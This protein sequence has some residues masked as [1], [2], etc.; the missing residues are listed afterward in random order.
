MKMYV[1]RDYFFTIYMPKIYIFKI[2]IHTQ[3]NTEVKEQGMHM[4]GSHVS[5][6][7]NRL[8]WHKHDLK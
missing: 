4:P 5:F 6:S 8:I 7:I 3:G 2:M 1:S